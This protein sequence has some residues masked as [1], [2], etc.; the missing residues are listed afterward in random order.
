MQPEREPPFCYEDIDRADWPPLRKPR[1][2]RKRKPSFRLTVAQATRAGL[3]N[4]SYTRNVDGSITVTPGKP[5]DVNVT[6]TPTIASE[7][8]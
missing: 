3:V 8:N 2:R 7:W 5:A 4:A 6:D 1:K